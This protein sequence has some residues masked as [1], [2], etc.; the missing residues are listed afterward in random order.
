MKRTERWNDPNAHVAL[1]R[2]YEER[3]PKGMTQEEFGATYGIG[4]QGMVWQYL[5]GHTPLSLEA[6]ARFARG[7]R[8]T[9]QDISPDLAAALQRDILPVLGPKVL[10]AALAKAAMVAAFIGLAAALPYPSSSQASDLFHKVR[11]A[12][13][14]KS[15]RW[16]LRWLFMIPG[17]EPAI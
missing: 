7:L 1:K 3:A 14:V 17:F 4:T 16:N 15:R 12:Y 13:Y 9:I 5:N 10:R 6:A 2:L 8:V 11:S